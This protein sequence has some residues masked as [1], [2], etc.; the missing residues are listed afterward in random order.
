MSYSPRLERL[1]HMIYQD[2]L[3]SSSEEIQET[4]RK[5]TIRRSHTRKSFKDFIDKLDYASAFIL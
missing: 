2:S 3:S 4:S 1:K 5:S